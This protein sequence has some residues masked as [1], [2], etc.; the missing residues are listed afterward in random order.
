MRKVILLVLTIYLIIAPITYHPDTKLVLYYSTLGNE[1]VWNIY[2]YLNEN[3]DNAPKFHYPPMNYWVVKSELPM[4]K[5]VG[6]SG[7][8]KWLG[9]GSNIA[10]LDK[11]IFRYNLASKLPLII[12]ILI[13]GFVI[14]KISIKSGLSENKARLVSL[15]WYLN[16]ITLYSGI[17]MGQNDILAITPF[18]IGWY[19]YF[20]YPVLAFLFFGL[21]SSVKS[22]PLIWAI[23]L[24]GV[25]PTKNWFKKIFFGL[26]PIIF[27]LITILPFIKYDYFVKDV[28]N[29]GLAMRMFELLFHI[30]SGFSIPIVPLLLIL[31]TLIG[32][33]NNLGTNFSGLATLLLTINLVILGFSNFNPQWFIWIMPFLSILLIKKSVFWNFFLISLALI[34]IVLLFDDK[35]LYW[36]LVSPI[37]HNLINLPF[38][39]EI[40]TKMNINVLMVNRFL[41][42]IIRLITFYWILNCAKYK[43]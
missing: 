33:K 22:F 42:L 19:Y 32:I 6:G 30:G 27:Y 7:I 10:F 3:I 5:L 14:Y 4:V 38:V 21:A 37:N 24:A 40:F 9:T 1:K 16:P 12:M 43:N 29:S 18:I 39:S 8:V 26:I 20:D 2:K 25:Y 13:T 34:G 31:V 11:D 41:H 15:I 17:V 35:F 28:M 36:G 23:A